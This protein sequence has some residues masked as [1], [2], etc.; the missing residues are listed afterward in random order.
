MPAL[1]HAFCAIKEVMAV[2]ETD[3]TLRTMQEA[4]L[5]SRREH[6]VRRLAIANV[7]LRSERIPRAGSVRTGEIAIYI[8]EPV[9]DVLKRSVDQDVYAIRLGLVLLACLRDMLASRNTA[10][11]VNRAGIPVVGSANEERELEEQILHSG[12]VDG[13]RLIAVLVEGCDGRGTTCAISIRKR[14]EKMVLVDIIDPREDDGVGSELKRVEL[15]RHPRDLLELANLWFMVIQL[16]PIGASF[17]HGYSLLV[18]EVC[19]TKVIRA[20][21]V[22]HIHRT[23]RSGS[24]AIH[25]NEGDNAGNIVDRKINKRLVQEQVQRI[26]NGVRAIWASGVNGL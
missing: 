7:H 21:V 24:L 3:R 25:V 15:F 1:L 14:I 6:L 20:H 10:V 17:V 9:V 13:F 8:A 23:I 16:K 4:M 18:G 11:Y 22:S 2:G 19:P 5:T 12:V 26:S